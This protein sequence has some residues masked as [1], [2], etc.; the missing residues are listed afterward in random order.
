MSA[1]PVDPREPTLLHWLQARLQNDQSLTWHDFVREVARE[2]KPQIVTEVVAAI[3]AT[4]KRK[5]GRRPNKAR[6]KDDLLMCWEWDT[7]CGS[8][9]DRDEELINRDAD[10]FSRRFSR[11]TKEDFFRA[12]GMTGL[13]E[14]RAA[15]KNLNRALRARDRNRKQPPQT[16]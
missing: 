7:F 3:R 1:T 6:I 2:I 15:V 9:L 14:I 13:H 10:G 16:E 4:P 5:A 12:K 11:R 8:P